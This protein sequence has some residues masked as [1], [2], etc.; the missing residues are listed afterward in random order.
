MLMGEIL[1]NVNLIMIGV[2][3]IECN[4]WILMR[5]KRI[6]KEMWVGMGIIWLFILLNYI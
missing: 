3:L 6:I 1:V 2:R 4:I 5:Y